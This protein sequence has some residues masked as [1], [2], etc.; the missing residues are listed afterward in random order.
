[1]RYLFELL[2]PFLAL[3]PRQEPELDDDGVRV[4]ARYDASRPLLHESRNIGNQPVRFAGPAL[5]AHMTRRRHQMLVVVLVVLSIVVLG[6][7]FG[8]DFLR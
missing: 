7:H 8:R 2:P 4:V 6:T 5:A 3:V 1:M